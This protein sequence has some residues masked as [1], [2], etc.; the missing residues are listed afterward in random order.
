LDRLYQ[1]EQSDYQIENKQQIIKE[2]RE[3]LN[4]S[5]KK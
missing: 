3:E 2:L 1:L 5:V 4:G